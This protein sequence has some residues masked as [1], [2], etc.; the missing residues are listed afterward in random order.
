[1]LHPNQQA[2]DYVWESLS[3]TFFDNETQNL[4]RQIEEVVQALNH[5]PR[6]PDSEAHKK[7]V[8]KNLE[9]MEALKN[10]LEA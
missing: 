1:M 9:K 6:N 2:I 7:F 3:N 8:E 5:R 10:K 4:L